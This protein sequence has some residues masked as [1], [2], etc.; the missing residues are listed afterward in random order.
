[1]DSV[2]LDLTIVLKSWGLSLDTPAQDITTFFDFVSH[3]GG[4]GDDLWIA[5][6]LAGD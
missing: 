3:L 1:M 4:G 5:M 2:E 6:L